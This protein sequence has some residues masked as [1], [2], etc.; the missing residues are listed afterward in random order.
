MAGVL[1]CLVASVLGGVVATVLRAAVTGGLVV[2][3]ALPQPPA[4]IAALTAAA[5]TRPCPGRA[6]L[7]RFT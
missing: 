1:A 4:A 7:C 3:D 5:R 2:V 6:E